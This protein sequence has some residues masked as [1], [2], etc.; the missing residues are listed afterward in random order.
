MQRAAQVRGKMKSCSRVGRK[1]DVVFILVAH[2]M[3]QP[4]DSCPTTLA[5]S[6]A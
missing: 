3:A 5:G 6:E 4:V 2:D 1:W